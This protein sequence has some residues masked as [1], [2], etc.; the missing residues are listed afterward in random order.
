MPSLRTVQNSSKK[1]LAGLPR[2]GKHKAQVRPQQDPIW[3][4]G[5]NN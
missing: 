5:T 3:P 2:A 4:D 1:D